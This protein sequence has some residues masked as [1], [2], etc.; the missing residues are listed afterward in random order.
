MNTSL[1]AKLWTQSMDVDRFW[2]LNAGLTPESAEVQLR[3]R[4]SKLEAT[5]IAS[6]QEHFD[7]AFASAYQ[8][9]LWAAAYLIEGGCSDDGFIDF[10]YGLI[11][12]GR[13]VFEAAIADPDSLVDIANDTDDGFIPNE[14]FGYVAQHVYESKTNQDMPEN[15]VV[16]PSEPGG[17]NWDFD[18]EQLCEQMLP[19]LWAKFGM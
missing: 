9:N 11:S 5:E 3:D 14:S 16:H 2:E 12:R 1:A 13:S 4:L 7:R 15:S 18:D 10:R 19:K 6:Y 8:W 17:E